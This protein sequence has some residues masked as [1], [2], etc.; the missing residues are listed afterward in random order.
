[1]TLHV[2]P[3]FYKGTEVRVAYPHYT[4]KGQEAEGSTCYLP[5]F[6]AN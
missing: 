4:T 3:A 5:L 2:I 6:L 1:M